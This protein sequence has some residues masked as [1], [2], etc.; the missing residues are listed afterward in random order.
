MTYGRLM[1]RIIIPQ[2]VLRITPGI[3]NQYVNCFKSTSIVSIIAVPDLMYYATMI[4]TSTFLPMPVYTLVALIYFFLVF[5]I[6][7]GVRMATA[8]LPNFSYYAAGGDHR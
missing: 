7:M 5:A 8:R 2:A 4:V 6:A 1:R 3:L